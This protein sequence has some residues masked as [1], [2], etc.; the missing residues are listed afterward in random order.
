MNFDELK[1]LYPDMSALIGKTFW[2]CDYRYGVDVLGNA[3]RN[4]KPT[5]A[6]LEIDTKKTNEFREYY[7]FR[8]VDKKG[9][10]LKTA[11]NPYDNTF[12]SNPI[13][14]FP[15][16]RE[17]LYHY[18]KQCVK[19]KKDIEEARIKLNDSLDKRIMKLNEIIDSI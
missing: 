15:N 8:K 10:L 9:E 19:N 2:I 5:E 7:L 12:S 14:V 6:V 18:K 16:E 1:E 3:I 17:C 11:I 13:N 4:I